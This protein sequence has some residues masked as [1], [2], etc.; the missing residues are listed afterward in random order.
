MIRKCPVTLE[1][2]LVQAVSLPT[3]THFIGEIAGAYVDDNVMKDGKQDYVKIDPL[4]LTMPDNC[5]WKL[6]KF[7]GDAW[8]LRK[9]LM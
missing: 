2:R 6:G 3:N 9:K 8:G 1:C 5:Y 4:F 7:A